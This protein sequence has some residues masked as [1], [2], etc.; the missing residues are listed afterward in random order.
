MKK[1]LLSFVTLSLLSST[2]YSQNFVK[3]TINANT[4]ARPFTIASGFLDG[5]AYLDLV[6]GSDV[7]SAVQWYKNNGD[8]TF[9]AAITLVATTPNA[10]TNINGIAI[11]DIDDDGDNDILATGYVSDNLV[12][13]ENN[14]DSTFQDAVEI[15]GNLDGAG[16]V[17]VANL[18]N[19]VNGYLDVIVS[20]NAPDDDTDSVIYLLGNGD[21]TFGS[22]QYISPQLADSGPGDIDLADF[23]EDGDLDVLIGYTGNGNVYVFDNRLIPDMSLSF[24]Q[25]TNPVDTGNGYLTDIAFGDLNDDGNLDI[26]KSDYSPS[27]GDAGI[28]WY[29]N[30]SS[31][32]AT[33]FT[34]HPV[35]TSIGNTSIGSVAD[36]NNDTYNDLLV[37]NGAVTD[38]DVIWF[39]SDNAGGL[40]SEILI[41]NSQSSIF[42]I[43]VQDF[44]ND[45]DLDFAT[46]SYF[47]NDLNLFLNDLIVLGTEEIL[48]QSMVIYPNPTKSSLNFKGFVDNLALSVY[49]V[50]GKNIMNASVSLNQSLDVSNLTNG[51]YF[52]KIEGS[53][54]TFKFIKE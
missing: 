35:P 32:T 43:E 24:T 39:V 6:T 20:L 11:A 23:D 45:G 38:D 12:W 50:I 30:D 27:G 25:Y 13:F 36:L 9:A 31:G 52:L 17:I 2:I 54:T 51:I 15:L 53:N 14:G 28:V 37:T 4:S 21:G 7:G 46:V 19:D 44:D 41:D 3:S 10:L 1:I 26:I 16:A 8:G 49:D 47:Q 18:D 42:D 22:L 48:N 33:T 5:D 29:T 34:A 40:G